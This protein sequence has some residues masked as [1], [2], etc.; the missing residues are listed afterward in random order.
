MLIIP[1]RII[2][3]VILIC[4]IDTHCTIE[5]WYFT[6]ICHLLSP[7]PLRVHKRWGI[8]PVPRAEEIYLNYSK[9][10]CS[11]G[12]QKGQRFIVMPKQ[13][14]FSDLPI[15]NINIPPSKVSSPV[16]II[17]GS[18]GER[19]LMAHQVLCLISRLHD[20]VLLIYDKFQ[21]ESTNNLVHTLN[22]NNS[23]L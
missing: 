23:W 15:V 7:T 21:V 22:T 16:A 1:T 18:Y 5:Y 17:S 10:S 14:T 13:I 20:W 4:D 12:D 9:F 8:K 11:F 6:R 2:Y 3:W 19:F